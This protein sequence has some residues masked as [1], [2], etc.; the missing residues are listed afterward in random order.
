MHKCEN[1]CESKY[2]LTIFLIIV[3]ITNKREFTISMTSWLYLRQTESWKWTHNISHRLLHNPWWW[4]K[5]CIPVKFDYFRYCTMKQ[6]S[7][8]ILFFLNLF[9]FYWPIRKKLCKKLIKTRK[10]Y[11]PQVSTNSNK[12]QS[13]LHNQLNWI[14]LFLTCIRLGTGE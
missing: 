7:Y 1:R 12:T 14:S 10:T 5:R 3:S 11:A 6:N 8:L 13:A 9:T 2:I 4:S